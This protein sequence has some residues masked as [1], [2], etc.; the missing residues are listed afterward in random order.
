VQSAA[1]AP[2]LLV[3]GNANPDEINNKVTSYIVIKKKLGSAL[4]SS[5]N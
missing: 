4:Y 5:G 3:D 2:N 1:S